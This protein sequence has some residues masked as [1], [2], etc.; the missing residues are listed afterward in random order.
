MSIISLTPNGTIFLEFEMCSAHVEVVSI[1]GSTRR[2]LASF[3]IDDLVTSLNK[4]GFYNSG[5][6]FVFLYEDSLSLRIEG[7]L[8]EQPIVLKVNRHDFFKEL[9]QNGSPI[10]KSLAVLRFYTY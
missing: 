5:V 6:N 8:S 10:E 4:K 9:S 1:E 7:N 3:L 2:L